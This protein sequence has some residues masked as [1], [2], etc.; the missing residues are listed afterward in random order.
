MS[1]TEAQKEAQ[2]I[3]AGNA[4]HIMLEGGSRSG[5]TF[6]LVRAVSMRAI[7]A[8]KSRHCILRFR[9]NH[10][11]AS[12]IQD[13]FPK[14]METCFPGVPYEMNKTDWYAA[15]PNGSEIWFGGLD[16]KV[17]SEKVLGREFSTIYL[18]EVSQIGL[19][20]RNLA[21][22]RLA[23]K[24]NQDVGGIKKPLPVRM[25][26]D[27]NPTSKGHWGYKMFHEK[28]DPDTKLALVDPNDYAFFRMNPEDNAA[29][30]S[31]SY[32]KLLRGLSD[33]Q[34]RRFLRGEWSDDNPNA[35]F[36]DADIDRW[37]VT[38]GRVPEL[39]R[40]LI[41][42]DP[43]GAGDQDNADNDAIGIIVGGLGTDGRGY[44]LEDLTVKAGPATWGRIATSAYDRH[45]AD[46]VLGESN[47]GGDMVRYTIQTSRPRTNYKSVSASRG[48]VVRAEPISAL[49]EQGKVCHVG[50]FP[51]LEE[52]L[53]SFSTSGYMGVGSPNRADALIWLLTEMFPS[54]TKPEPGPKR[55]STHKLLGTPQGWMR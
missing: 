17:R 39:V 44:I 52:E 37:R 45:K 20:S 8:A 42:V 25:Y 16:D 33:R 12:I 21:V 32:L 6:L 14:V 51:E 3:L 34:Q 48:K 40:V 23:Q 28:R 31:D 41:A 24:I 38:D 2:R 13:T 4:T 49:Y 29:N 9:F 46:A 47:F 1:L 22:T 55:E 27:L 53:T 50:Y 11:K 36:N 19:D 5:K 18:N 43:S 35:L 54:L 26:Y 10:I 7:K 15:L 30:L